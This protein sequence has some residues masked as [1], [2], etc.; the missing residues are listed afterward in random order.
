M[1]NGTPM[2][3]CLMPICCKS[4][5]MQAYGATACVCGETKQQQ[6]HQKKSTMLLFNVIQIAHHRMH[7]K[8]HEQP[9][10][11]PHPPARKI[12]ATATLAGCSPPIK[13]REP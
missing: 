2:Q 5:Y 12:P 10:P 13:Q 11:L 3:R 7:T 4:A 9:L 8:T 6:C 1:L